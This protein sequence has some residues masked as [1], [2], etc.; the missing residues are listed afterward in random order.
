MLANLQVAFGTFVMVLWVKRCAYHSTAL[1][2]GELPSG[3]SVLVRKT[4]EGVIA[5]LER[6]GGLSA[7]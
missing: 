3:F 7:V 4:G 1:I 2:V 5:G 6:G